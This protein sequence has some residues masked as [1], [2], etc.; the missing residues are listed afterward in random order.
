MGVL[1]MDTSKTFDSLYMYHPL[2]LAKLR[3]YGVE[4]SSL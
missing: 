2:T 1:S 4:E 3:A